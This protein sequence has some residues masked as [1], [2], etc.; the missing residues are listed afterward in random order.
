MYYVL[1]TL[2]G[3]CDFINLLITQLSLFYPPGGAPLRPG[4]SLT[5][6]SV[7]FSMGPSVPAFH[8]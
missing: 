8:S 7:P 1:G 5:S 6:D 3:T 2:Q 4:S